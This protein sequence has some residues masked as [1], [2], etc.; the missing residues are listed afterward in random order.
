MLISFTGAQST[1]K[2][3][4]LNEC[5]Q[6]PAFRKFHCVPEVTRK[7]AREQ[8]VDI[9][10][11]GGDITQLFILNEH[12]RNHYI[13]G[14]ALLDRCILDGWVYTDYLFDQGKVSLWVRDYAQQLYRK[15]LTQLDVIFYTDPEDIPIED[16][17]QRSTDKNFRSDIIRGFEY[18]IASRPWG[19]LAEIPIDT[20]KGLISN[21]VIVRL[22][23]DVVTRMKT[24][25]KTIKKYDNSSIR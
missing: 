12:L 22:E 9:N 14:P 13:K 1:G 10:E 11:G 17:G 4:L 23:G 19:I 18:E 21:P 15:L 16:D 5:C 7:V 25:L 6:S 24:I 3:T 8:H 20:V 2:T